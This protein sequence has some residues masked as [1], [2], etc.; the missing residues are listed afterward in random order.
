MDNQLISELICF[1][2]GVMLV[3]FGLSKRTQ[4]H[5]LLKKGIK[6]EGVVFRM[7]K[8][9]DN[10]LIVSKDPNG[11]KSASVFY[12]PVIRYVT[13]EKEWIT[14]AYDVS[15][16]SFGQYNEGDEV[17]VFYDP[18]D[19]NKFIIDDTSTKLMGPILIIIGIACMLG[20][21]VYYFFPNIITHQ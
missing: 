3:V 2:I 8:K 1:L 18:S 12:Y 14:Q 5:E 11:F 7:E 13:R 16:S 15:V 10:P 6:T 19:N 4:R 21:I 17:V 9:N 20:T